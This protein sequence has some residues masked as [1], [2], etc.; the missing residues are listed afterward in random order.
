MAS[1]D[2]IL[3]WGLVT[4]EGS[5]YQLLDA[6]VIQTLDKNDI[7]PM[8]KQYWTML[9]YT[10]TKIISPN[11][12]FSAK[13]APRPLT[14]VTETGTSTLYDVTYSPAK[15]IYQRIIAGSYMVSENL[16][17]WIKNSKT[18]QGAPDG[19]Q[20]DF[21]DVSYRTR[22]LTLSYDMTFA[23]ELVKVLTKWFSITSWAW[24][25][26][27]T[28]KG[29]SLFDTHTYNGWTFLNYTNG[30]L[31]FTS[32]SSDLL[33]WTTR[34]QTLINQL[35]QVRD[36]NGYFIREP[37][38]YVLLCSRQNSVFWRQVLND[39]SKFSGQGTNA[40][41][42]N[43]FNWNGNK[44]ELQIIDLL[45]QPDDKGVSIGT[46]NQ[47]FVLNI[48]WLTQTQSLRYYRLYPLEIKSYKN[49]AVWT[50]TTD[51]RWRIGADHYGA[52][53]FIAWSTCAS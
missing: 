35:K 30:A 51:A 2:L 50:V 49:E 21:I 48:E 52:E 37:S 4:F 3:A 28:P 46:V 12:K 17:K 14:D 6:N 31:T 34:L 16:L 5:W 9:G 45:W 47:I 10:D 41:Q 27:P 25:G 40:M 38:K 36:E 11:Q 19:V 22:D 24:P 8:Y 26:S 42:E 18:I 33:A 15:W 1:T 53:L 32:S 44:I 39:G 20:A 29:K 7:M 23:F 13:S 43:Q